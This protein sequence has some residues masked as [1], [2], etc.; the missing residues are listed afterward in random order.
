MRPF[1]IPMSIAAVLAAAG[2]AQALSP[3]AQRGFVFV[4]TNCSR[5]HAIGR[6]GDNLMSGTLKDCPQDHP[7]CKRIIDN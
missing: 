3:A 5:C 6:F 4:D 1:V 7:Y 2:S